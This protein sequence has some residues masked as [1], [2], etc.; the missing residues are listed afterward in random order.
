MSIAL[1]G[2]TGAVGPLG[3]VGV[4]GGGLAAGVPFERGAD[5]R[6][7]GRV[8]CGP[9]GQRFQLEGG[10]GEHGA[11]GVAPPVEVGLG[12]VDA[13]AVQAEAARAVVDCCGYGDGAGQVVVPGVSQLGTVVFGAGGEPLGA[14]GRG[15]LGLIGGQASGVAGAFERGEDSCASAWLSAIRCTVL[16]CRPRVIPT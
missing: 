9:V 12:L 1:A 7:A 10:A 8:L 11:P 14:A 16:A 15:L 6:R 2:L 5:V 4:L 13:A 3:V